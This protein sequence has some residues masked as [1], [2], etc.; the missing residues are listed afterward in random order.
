MQP[1]MNSYADLNGH[2]RGRGFDNPGYGRT[3]QG[4]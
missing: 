1:G 2:G 4:R 3:H